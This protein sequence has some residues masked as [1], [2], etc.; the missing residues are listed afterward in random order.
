MWWWW[1]WLACP[2]SV[3]RVSIT[4]G[5]NT[6]HAHTHARTQIRDDYGKPRTIRLPSKEE[7]SSSDDDGAASSS[8][9]EYRGVMQEPG[10]DVCLDLGSGAGK[11]VFAAA[12]LYPFKR[13]VGIEV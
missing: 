12:A 4:D 11:P 10:V 2:A 1:L 8:S 3:C 13:V 6:Q 9:F 7:G 5:P